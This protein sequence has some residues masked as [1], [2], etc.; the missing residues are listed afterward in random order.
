MHLPRKGKFGICS[1][2]V[3]DKSVRMKPTPLVPIHA[4]LHVEVGAGGGGAKHLGL[5]TLQILWALI[6]FSASNFG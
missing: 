2:G 5:A 1:S 4:T 6:D 3:V